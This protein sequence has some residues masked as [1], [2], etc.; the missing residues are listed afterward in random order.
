MTSTLPI[1]DPGEQDALLRLLAAGGP[2]EPRRRLLETH[3]S[4]TAALAAGAANWRAC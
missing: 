3:G 2:A 4:A 1:N